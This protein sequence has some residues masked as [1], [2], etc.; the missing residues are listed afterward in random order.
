MAVQQCALYG[1]FTG[2]ADGSFE[3][4]DVS[5]VAEGLFHMAVRGL[6]AELVDEE[7]SGYEKQLTDEG[8]SG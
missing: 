2:Q 6:P 8:R 5:G 3:V 4:P 1:S 7:E